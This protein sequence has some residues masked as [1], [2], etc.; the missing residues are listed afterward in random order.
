[1]LT[2]ELRSK[3]DRVWDA[4][5]T[6]GVSN[7]LT[8]IKQITYL[9]FIKRLDE[10]HTVRENKANLLKKEI[11]DPVFSPNQQEFRWNRFR[12][13]DPEKMFRLFTRDEG[14]FDFMKRYGA[15]SGYT[16]SRYVK[17]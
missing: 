3:V 13:L 10:L 14:V 9:L 2:G 8:V 12:D 15:E 4:F 5:W 11:E 1:M 17:G 7:P 6:G 16:Y